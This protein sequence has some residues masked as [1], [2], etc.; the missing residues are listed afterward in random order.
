MQNGWT[1]SPEAIE[2][3][4]KHAIENPR[5]WAKNPSLKGPGGSGR[6]TKDPAK[7]TTSV[8]EDCGTVHEHY[9]IRPKKYCSPECANK[10]KYHPNS[11]R[12]TRSIYKEFQ[13]DSGSELEFAK[14]CDE[15]NIKWVKNSTIAYEY[16]NSKNEIR[17]YYPDFYLEEYDAW[18]EI[19]SKYYLRED[20]DLRWAS[21]PKHE[22]IWSDNITLPLVITN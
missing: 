13:M 16:T 21:V 8:C 18:V 6:R 5:G 14:L 7:W 15:H 10:N 2:K 12:K 3:I 11:T 1:H 4:R 9:K 19:K 20:D 22:V 17:N